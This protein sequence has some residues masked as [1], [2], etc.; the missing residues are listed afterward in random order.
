MSKDDSSVIEQLEIQMKFQE[1]K[2]IY[3]LGV[4]E[5]KC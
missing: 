3:G 4:N 5:I 2:L 1:S